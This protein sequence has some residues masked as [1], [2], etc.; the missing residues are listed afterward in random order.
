MTIVCTTEQMGGTVAEADYEDAVSY[1][2]EV[3]MEHKGVD[4]VCPI[5]YPKLNWRPVNA[6]LVPL[7]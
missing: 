1:I 7:K 3:V 2:R 6:V 4:W 5:I